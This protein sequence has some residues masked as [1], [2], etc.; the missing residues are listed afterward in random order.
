M[1]EDTGIKEKLEISEQYICLCLSINVC[2]IYINTRK[3]LYAFLEISSRKCIYF[4]IIEC[5]YITLT[6]RWHYGI[7]FNCIHFTVPYAF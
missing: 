6:T 3:Y 5:F 4:L 7:Y 1:V 2:H